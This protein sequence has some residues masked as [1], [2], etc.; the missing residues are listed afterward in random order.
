MRG[1]VTLAAALALP[2][3]TDSGSPLPE[4]NVIVFLA[5]A[6]IVVTL[7]IQGLTLPA[8]VRAVDLPADPR[9]PQEEAYAW[10]RAMEAGLA[11]LEELHE[12]PWVD[13]TVVQRLRDTL[14]ANR[15]VQRA[16]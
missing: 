14:T 2:L 7:V 3:A 8:L 11:R 1:A 4:R 5:F 16:Q 9:E 15:A 12:E 10:E 6:V 13:P